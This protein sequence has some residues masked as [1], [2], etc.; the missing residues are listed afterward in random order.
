MVALPEFVQR[1]RVLVL[2]PVDEAETGMR[3]RVIRFQ[4]ER[5][6][7]SRERSRRIAFSAP[8]HAQVVMSRGQFR[9]LLHRLLE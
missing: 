3:L 8:D 4:I 5:F 1:P 6:L 7:I 9:A 2:L